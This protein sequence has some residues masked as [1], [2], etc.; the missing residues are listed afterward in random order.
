[1]LE[2]ALGVLNPEDELI[3]HSDQVCIKK[4]LKDLSPVKYRTQV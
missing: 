1:M 4:K 3:F 2:Q